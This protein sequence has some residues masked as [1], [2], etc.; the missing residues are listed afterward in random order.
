[1]VAWAGWSS[2]RPVQSTE[3]GKEHLAKAVLASSNTRPSGQYLS[4]ICKKKCERVN[5]RN[6]QVCNLVAKFL[7][8]MH[9]LVESCDINYFKEMLPAYS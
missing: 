3:N 7:P 1:M 2:G 5:F 4:N 8:S 6:S 9:G